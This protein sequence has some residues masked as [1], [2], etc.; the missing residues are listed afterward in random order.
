MQ[1]KPSNNILLDA[2]AL[3]VQL[4]QNSLKGPLGFDREISPRIRH[5]NIQ[6]KKVFELGDKNFLFFRGNFDLLLSD[7]QN[8]F[9]T[10]FE[11]YLQEGEQKQSWKLARRLDLKGKNSQEWI[12]YPLPIDK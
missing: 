6:E 5:L 1:A 10:P 4:T 3:Q 11:L 8:E 12:L 9:K 7:G 2:L